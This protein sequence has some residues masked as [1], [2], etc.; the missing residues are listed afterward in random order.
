M[1]K[2]D[3]PIKPKIPIG[4]RPSNRT[5]PLFRG[6]RF[7]VSTLND[8]EILR[9]LNDIKAKQT[10]SEE[11]REFVIDSIQSLYNKNI[12]NFNKEDLVFI[13]E[14]MAIAKDICLSSLF[15]YTKDI[16]KDTICNKLD[17]KMEEIQYRIQNSTPR[18]SSSHKPA[19]KSTPY[20]RQGGKPTRKKRTKKT[21]TQKRTK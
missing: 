7:S 13:L 17:T 12:T 16:E 10:I 6:R 9:E 11:D 4:P 15:Y 18:Q 1:Q 14:A 2:Y 21:S 8:Y 19:R 5:N 3:S 20:R